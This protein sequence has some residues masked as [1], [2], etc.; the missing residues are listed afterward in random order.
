MQSVDHAPSRSC[1]S[2]ATIP[3]GGPLDAASAT[4]FLQRVETMMAA[5]VPVVECELSAPAVGWCTVAALLRAAHVARLS[6]GTFLV[7]TDD[8]VVR[9]ELQA[10]GLAPLLR[11]G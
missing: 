7:H 9:A 4:A 2:R 3:L 1:R 8:P 5:G 11:A 10:K 6:G